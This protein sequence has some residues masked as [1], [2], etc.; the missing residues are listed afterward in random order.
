MLLED[1]SRVKL[2]E[3]QATYIQSRQVKASSGILSDSSGCLL[4][5]HVGPYVSYSRIRNTLKNAAAVEHLQATDPMLRNSQW[6]EQS[7][8]RM[9]HANPIRLGVG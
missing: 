4:K 5:A 3:A 6:R 7:A 8:V 1:E 2:L 9:A